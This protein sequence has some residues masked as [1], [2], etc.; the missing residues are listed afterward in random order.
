MI[1]KVNFNESLFDLDYHEELELLKTSNLVVEEEE[2]PMDFSSRKMKV[3]EKNL[4]KVWEVT[5]KSTK[6]DW[7]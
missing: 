4:K 7:T 5:Q 6:E 2:T 1:T 3:N